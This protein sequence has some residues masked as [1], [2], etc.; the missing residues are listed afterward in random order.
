[1]RRQRAAV[2]LVEVLVA[3]FVMG[4]GMIALLTLF[5]IG[6]LRMQQAINDELAAQSANNAH[7]LSLVYNLRND[8]AVGAFPGAIS[9]PLPGGNQDFLANPLPGTLPSADPFGESYAL[10]VDPLGANSGPTSPWVGGFI[11]KGILLRRPVSY[12]STQAAINSTFTL[13]D[14]LSFNKDLD[15]ALG[16]PGTPEL[17][18]G[19]GTA[20]LRNSRF[21]WVYTLRRP[22]TSDRSVVDCS[23]VVFNS[24]SLSLN[25]N[26][27]LGE[28]VYAPL[29][30]VSGAYF[31]FNPV[32]NNN[33]P[34][35]TITVYYNQATGLIA[36]QVRPGN[37]I[38]DA[39][40]FTTKNAAGVVS[41]GQHAYWYRV[42]STTDAIDAGGNTYT[43]FEVQGSIRGFNNAPTWVNNTM[44]ADPVSGLPSYQ[45]TIV[46]LDGVVEV[47][48]KGPVH[49]Q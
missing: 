25:A 22:V 32:P 29:G 16:L 21:S 24:R 39:T 3:I 13:W 12:A 15:P 48:E 11:N 9:D 28:N 46:I 23:I 4:I 6:V 47:F 42:L 14:D 5:P 2:T 38:M 36:P 26:L 45:G 20:V 43:V 34:T 44:V 37:W 10:L 35:N 33:V 18:A 17:A 41:G 27:N 7:T 49:Q 8:M 31:N 1:M 40:Q 19:P 30:G